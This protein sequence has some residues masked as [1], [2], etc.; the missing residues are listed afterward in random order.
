MKR[1]A[2]DL[3][4]GCGGLSLGLADA[5]FDVVAGLDGW[6]AAVDVYKA[7]NPAHD[8]F[9]F[10]LSHEADTVEIVKRYR[11]FLVA[12]GPPCQDYSPAGGR[13]EGVRAEL[14]VGF[15]RVVVGSG[16][17]SFIMENVPRAR[18]SSTFKKAMRVFRKAGFGMTSVVLNAALCGVPQARQ[19]LFLIG[20]KG[21]RDDFLLSSI[22]EGLSSRPMTVREYDPDLV[23]FDHYYRHPRTYQ[24]KAIFSI[25]EPSPT[26]R[27][28]NRPKPPTY[29]MH[30]ND[31]HSPS[32]ARVQALDLDQRARL[33]TFPSGYFDISIS[34][35]DKEQMIG[36]AVP[37][38]LARF[39]AAALLDYASTR[40]R[41][42]EIVPI[43]VQAA[44]MAE[45]IYL[46]TVSRKDRF[47][48]IGRGYEI[49]DSMNPKI[50]SDVYNILARLG[51]NRQEWPAAA[52]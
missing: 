24:R 32:D 26:I 45:A 1:R 4:C 31:S 27:G 44:R 23:G 18:L 22:E 20:L 36:N 25:D 41:L 39:V 33:Q 19:R 29:K 47:D 16:A 52:E 21:E 10:D 14:T 15:A 2:V 3:F 34:K 6:K 28:V 51:N 17:E 49:T 46:H 30:R 50:V 9:V 48:A 42:T 5:G 7:N 13:I 11:P 38:L 43:E 40:P 12:G 37:P 8:C 35:A